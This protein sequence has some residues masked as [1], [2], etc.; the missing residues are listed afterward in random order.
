MLL[1]TL[2]IIAIFVALPSA[3][4]AGRSTY[5]S[6]IRYLPNSGCQTV[7]AKTLKKDKTV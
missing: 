6:C 4:D 2:A 5:C 1:T 3:I 7:R